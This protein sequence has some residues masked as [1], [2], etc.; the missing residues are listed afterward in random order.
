[1][2]QNP[3]LAGTPIDDT[4]DFTLGSLG[5]EDDFA[6]HDESTPLQLAKGRPIE[7]D[8]EPEEDED[9]EEQLSEQDKAQTPEAALPEDDDEFYGATPQKPTRQSRK[10]KSDAI[11]ESEIQKC[12]DLCLKAC[13]RCQ[14]SS[15]LT[16]LI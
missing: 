13:L 1:M 4:T 5:D 11:E 6:P 9:E 14:R 10:R 7:V 15:R 3:E 2:V 16:M 12:Q 8:Q